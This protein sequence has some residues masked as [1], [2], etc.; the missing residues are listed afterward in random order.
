ML[1]RLLTALAVLALVP[2]VAVP[3]SASGGTQRVTVVYSPH[4]DDETLRLTGYVGTAVARGDHVILVAVTDGEAT[5][6][7]RLWGFRHSQMADMRKAEQE[8]AWLWIT[9]GRGT[10]VRLGIP[11][12]EVTG[13]KAQITEV[14]RELET[15]YK[16]RNVEHYVAAHATDASPDHRSTVAAV[17]DA[18]PRVVR[19]S[20]EPGG[21]RAGARYLPPVAQDAKMAGNS[22]RLIGQVSVR[23][24]FAAAAD[25]GYASYIVP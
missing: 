22:Y 10:V 2:L 13:H 14:A 4:P 15:V 7:T 24:L 12:G 23:R 9:K 8:H 17:R 25:Q 19:Y 6:L 3:A 11:D 21:T 20:H 18:R 5:G 16:D 1:R